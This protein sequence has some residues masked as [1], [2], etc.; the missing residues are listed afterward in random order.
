MMIGIV[1]LLLTMT[2]S[3]YA[4]NVCRSIPSG[5][6]MANV[7]IP[8]SLT[9]TVDDATYYVIDEIISDGLTIT[10]PG[11]G[12]TTES[13]HLKWIV[14]TDATDTV[15][16]YKVQGLGGPYFL[17]GWFQIEGMLDPSVINGDT[18]LDL[19]AEGLPKNGDISGDGVIDM[20]DVVH[21]ARHYFFLESGMFPENEIIYADGDIDC[22]GAIDMDDVVYLARHYFFLESGMFPEYENLYPCI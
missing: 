3:A 13:G 9:V 17:Y 12:D 2:S 22:S 1:M 19:S 16:T 11:T 21:L 8:I 10:D 4:S 14:T 15:Y 5:S 7:D 20:D 6:Q 18:N